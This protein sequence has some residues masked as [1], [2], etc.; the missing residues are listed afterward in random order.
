M[1]NP[2]SSRPLRRVTL[3]LYEED[4]VALEREHGYGWT[5]RVRETIHES[6]RKPRVDPPVY[7]KLKLG[8]LE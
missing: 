5:G 4:C 6:V 7:Q 8:D 3:N 1:P 2:G